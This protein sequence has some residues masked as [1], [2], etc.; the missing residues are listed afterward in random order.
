M[1]GNYEQRNKKE[2]TGK[3]KIRKKNGGEKCF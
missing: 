1:Y 3:Y 2:T